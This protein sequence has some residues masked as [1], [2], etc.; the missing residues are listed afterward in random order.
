MNKAQRREALREQLGPVL[1]MWFGEWATD[2]AIEGV[3][4]AVYPLLRDAYGNGRNAADSRAGYR[5]TQENERL[6][7]EL[8]QIKKGLA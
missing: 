3:T 4:D 5:L 6:R 1:V 7:R 8:E 2:V